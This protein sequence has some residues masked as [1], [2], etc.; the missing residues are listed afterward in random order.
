MNAISQGLEEAEKTVNLQDSQY[1]LNRELS[2]L[3]FNDR[4]LHE[5]SDPR[6]PLL[7]RLKFAAIF[8][9]NLDEFF[10]VRISGLMEQIEA[11]VYPQIPDGSSPKA[12]LKVLHEHLVGKVEEQHHLFE[13]ELRPALA[14]SGILLLNYPDLDTDQRRVVKNYFEDHVFPVLTPLSVDPAHP[15]PQ[16]S[17]LSLNLAVIVE[18]PETGIERFARVKVPDSLPR[19]VTLSNDRNGKDESRP[20]WVGLALEQVIAQ[21]LDRLFPGMLIKAHY[22]F[23]ITRDADFPLKEEE[24][25]D[26]LEAI[27]EEVNKRRLDGFVCRLEV[28]RAM[29]APER[30]WLIKALEITENAV[31]EIEGLL[32][33][34]DLFF[35]MGLPFPAL[36]DPPWIPVVPAR[37]KQIRIAEAKDSAQDEF[38]GAIFE[39]IKKGDLLVHHPYE[40]FVA[41]VEEFIAQ[42]AVDPQVMAIKLTLYRTS[43]DSPIV[44]SLMTAAENHKQVA[45]LVE[46]K[47]RFDE[48]NNIA[49]AQKLEDS[50]VHVVYGMVGLKTHTKTALVVREE[51]GRFRR[52][53]HIGTGNYNPKTAKLY[54]DLGLLSCREELGADLSDLFNYLTGYSRHD[55]YRKLLV[56]PLTL[57]PRMQGLIEQEIRHARNGNG[58]QIIAKMNSLVDADMI[59]LLYK[60]SQSGVRID[61]IIRG[62]CC[63]RPGIPG[64]SEN[65]RVISVIGRYLE[66]ARI[67]YFENHGKEEIYI[68][69]ADWMTRN[70]NRRVEAVVPIEDTNL[71][72]ELRMILDI[73]LQDNRQAWDMH[74]DGHYVQRRPADGEEERASQ[75]LL[76]MRALANP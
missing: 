62:I 7:E 64:V 31:Y 22:L 51:G 21:H 24:A 39:E 45:A 43:G 20:T 48:K 15:F 55:A 58:G 27:A 63:L 70:L 19:F 37:F 17:N 40:S 29:Q 38:P 33:L 47:A 5:A 75:S 34:K 13:S 23:R 41:T 35:F 4:V 6:T 11:G 74:P 65:I 59:R 68:G 25:D 54:T 60:A 50:G 36:M 57:R 73:Q 46:L 1:Y 67:F 28:E 12:Q 3:R 69:S 56:A 53:V 10:M 26:L 72:R 49:W 32:N 18:D 2:W 14:E 61:L 71:K 8:S 76:M 44:H 30:E 42:A 16:M 66:H 52:Y 9:S